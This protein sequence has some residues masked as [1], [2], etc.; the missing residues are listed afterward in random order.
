M[1]GSMCKLFHPDKPS[2][3]CCQW[4]SVFSAKFKAFAIAEYASERHAM[5]QVERVGRPR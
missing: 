3:G 4:V 5:L 2:A 1:A